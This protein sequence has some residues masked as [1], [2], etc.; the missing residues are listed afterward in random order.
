MFGGAKP[1]KAPR[2]D[3]TDGIVQIFGDYKIKQKLKIV[4]IAVHH[5]M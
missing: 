3:G 5:L 4:T 2:G 1:T